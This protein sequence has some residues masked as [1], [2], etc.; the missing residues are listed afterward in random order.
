MHKVIDN[1]PLAP[2]ITKIEVLR[3]NAPEN[4]YKV[5]TDFMADSTVLDLD[6]QVVDE[7]ITICKTHRIKLPDAIIA[8]TASV[9]KLQ[10]LTRNVS[11]FHHIKGL[12][13]VNPHDL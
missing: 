10:L 5:L 2:V 4:A 9:F 3:Y 8:A 1:V 12:K 13:V 11:D 6:N 7:T